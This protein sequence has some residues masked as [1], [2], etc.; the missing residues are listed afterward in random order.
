MKEFGQKLKELRKKK[1]LSQEEL[2]DAAKINLRTIQ[3]IENNENIPRGKTL[4]LICEA[5]E[6]NIEDILDYGKKEDR[7]YLVYLHL[8]VLAFLVIPLGNIILPLILWLSGKDRII[9]L[10]ETGANILNFQI[11]WTILLGLAIIGHISIIFRYGIRLEFLY[12]IVF[13]YV[14]NIMLSIIFTFKSGYGR[15]AKMYPTIFRLVK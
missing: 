6:I 9:G 14:V 7:K 12:F 15:P 11:F 13:L 4:G 2:A 5:L 10:K 3:R 8:S 1:G